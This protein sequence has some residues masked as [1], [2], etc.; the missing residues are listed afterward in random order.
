MVGAY[1]ERVFSPLEVAAPRLQAM[2]HGKKLLLSGGLVFLCRYK[3]AALI[4][5]GFTVLQQNS[6]IS[7]NTSVGLHDK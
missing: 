3:F 4:C 6:P 2:Y 1:D 7:D 5:D